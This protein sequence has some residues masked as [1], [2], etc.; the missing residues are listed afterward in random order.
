MPLTVGGHGVDRL[1]H[2]ASLTEQIGGQFAAGFA[3]THLDEAPHHVDA[4]ARYL[5]GYFAT[6][7]IRP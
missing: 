2:P 7:A 1:L 5:P 3:L 4:T 6:R